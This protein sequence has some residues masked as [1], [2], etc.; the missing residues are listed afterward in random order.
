MKQFASGNIIMVLLLAASIGQG[1]DNDPP[2]QRPQQSAEYAKLRDLV[3]PNPRE[4][5]YRKMGWRTSVLRG[6]VDAQKEDRPVM[7]VLMNGHPLG[8]T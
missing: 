2:L 3:L 7:I 8:C 4:Q 5:S 1:A 6:I